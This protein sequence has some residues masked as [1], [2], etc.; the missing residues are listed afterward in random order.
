MR[1]PVW[2]SAVR[3]ELNTISM[4]SGLSVHYLVQDIQGSQGGTSIE[5]MV[6]GVTVQFLEFQSKPTAAIFRTGLC[7]ETWKK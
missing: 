2:Y 1:T 6:L 4:F 5:C 3:Y 7:Q